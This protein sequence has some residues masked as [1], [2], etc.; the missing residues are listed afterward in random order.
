MS[1][2][3][4][5][6][7]K[8][9]GTRYTLKIPIRVR[10]TDASGQD[11]EE[12]SEILNVSGTGAYFLSGLPLRLNQEIF[13]SLPLPRKMRLV[14]AADPVFKCKARVVRVETNLPQYPAGKMGVA[15]RFIVYRTTTTDSR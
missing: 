9:V 15:V 4:K 7:Q 8:R 6:Q 10:M 1:T 5:S 13:V 11:F 3:K 14:P 2:T 12:I